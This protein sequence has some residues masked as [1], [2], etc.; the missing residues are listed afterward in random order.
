M[1]CM[2]TGKDIELPC[3]KEIKTTGALLIH[4]DRDESVFEGG[5]VLF[6]GFSGLGSLIHFDLERIDLGRISLQGVCNF[7]LEIIDNN[8]IREERQNNFDFQ[9][10]CIFKELH[11]SSI[12]R[13]QQIAKRKEMRTI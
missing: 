9:Q 12:M 10:I 2:V 1:E 3:K 13:T 5:N 11:G 6:Y 7:F 8:E 4:V